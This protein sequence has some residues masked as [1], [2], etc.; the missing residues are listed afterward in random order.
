MNH[1]TTGNCHGEGGEGSRAG[2]L[3]WSWGGGGG[4]LKNGVGGVQMAE[5]TGGQGGRMGQQGKNRG[6]LKKKKR[7]GYRKGGG[8]N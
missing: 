2:G 6:S 5:M 1:Y 4:R 8:S 7:V 3:E